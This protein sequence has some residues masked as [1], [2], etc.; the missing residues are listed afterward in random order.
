MLTDRKENYRQHKKLQSCVFELFRC[1]SR[2]PSLSATSTVAREYCNCQSTF[3][4]LPSI[5]TSRDKFT[6]NVQ[7]IR[8]Q[9]EIALMHGTFLLKDSLNRFQLKCSLYIFASQ[10]LRSK[11]LGKGTDLQCGCQCSSFNK[12][13]PISAI[14]NK[15][16]QCNLAVFLQIF[17]LTHFFKENKVLLEGLRKFMLSLSLSGRYNILFLQ[18]DVG[19]TDRFSLLKVIDLYVYDICRTLQLYLR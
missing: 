15:F 3:F 9:K 6:F 16:I 2:E 4:F 12:T 5:N 8:E 18:L 13:P 14:Q 1:C 17:L 19:Y 10:F 7:K 11:A